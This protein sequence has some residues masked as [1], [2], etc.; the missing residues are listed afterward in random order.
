[1]GHAVDLIIMPG[2]WK[3]EYLLQESTKPGGFPWKINLTA[4]DLSRLRQQPVL[5]VALGRDPDRHWHP[6]GQIRRSEFLQK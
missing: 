6:K 2:V 4:L 3:S 5:F 1:L